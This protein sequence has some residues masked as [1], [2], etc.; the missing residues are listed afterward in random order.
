ML[1]SPRAL[2]GT[3]LPGSVSSFPTVQDSL[4]CPVLRKRRIDVAYQAIDTEIHVDIGAKF[5]FQ[6]LRDHSRA[7]AAARWLFH[8]RAVIFA[9]GD[10]E[11]SAA[12]D[13]H[14]PDE[15]N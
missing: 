14:V 1:R 10:V 13:L 11:P 4:T 15:V 2:S 9:P 7:E 6:R 12:V 8:R 3:R 5:R